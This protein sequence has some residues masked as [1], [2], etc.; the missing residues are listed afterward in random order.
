MMKRLNTMARRAGIVLG[1]WLACITLTFAAASAAP[2]VPEVS[3]WRLG[4]HPEGVTRVVIDLSGSLNYSLSVLSNPDRLVIR[5]PRLSW[6]A[7]DNVRPLGRVSGLSYEHAGKA[8]GRITVA[9]RQ[10]SDVKSAFFI[11]PRNGQGWRLVVD[12]HAVATKERTEKELKAPATSP[13]AETIPVKELAPPPMKSA[14]LV[15]PSATRTE[16]APAKVVQKAAADEVERPATAAKP[17]GGSVKSGPILTAAVPQPLRTPE[18]TPPSKPVVVVDPG[19]GGVDPGAIGAS[20][21]YEKNITL[22]MARELKTHLEKTGRYKVVLTRNRDVFLRLRDRVEI[23]RRNKADLFISLHADAMQ[24]ASTK[25]FSVYTLSKTA[26]DSEAAALADKEN[27]ADLIVGIDLS[28]ESADVA[29][30]LIDLAQ[31]ETMNHSAAFASHAV[32]E[33]GRETTALR[34]THRFAGF[35]VL[36]APDVPSVLVELGYLSNKV[37]ERNLRQPEYRA[38][39]AKGLVRA[40][41]RFFLREQKASRP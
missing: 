23:A 11:P 5:T 15:I 26:S 38:K 36:K 12:L 39:L 7:D 9:L 18:K 10:T 19:H 40:V 20:G 2:Q 17:S 27:K 13:A 30:I 25:G 41:D 37:E 6:K 4:S 21:V 8:A 29:N 1:M 14:P 33:V 24:D 16:E 32:D 35:A 31:R 28:H 34:N 22:A 3:A